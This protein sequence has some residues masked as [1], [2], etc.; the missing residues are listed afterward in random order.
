MPLGTCARCRSPNL[1]FILVKSDVGDVQNWRFFI[2]DIPEPAR[3][4]QHEHESTLHP[5][6]KGPKYL[7]TGYLGLPYCES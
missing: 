5:S 6:P 3:S 7:T 4:E 1:S 2:R